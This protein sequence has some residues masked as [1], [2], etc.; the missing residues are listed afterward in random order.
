M[1]IEYLDG[2]DYPDIIRQVLW[3]GSAIGNEKLT[4]SSSPEEKD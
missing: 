3:G 2:T 4:A 1:E